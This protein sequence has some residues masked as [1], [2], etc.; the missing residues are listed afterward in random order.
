[1][2][3]AFQQ[4]PRVLLFAVAGGAKEAPRPHVP[5]G[6]LVSE[7]ACKR[8]GV[9]VRFVVT[10]TSQTIPVRY[11]GILP[12]LFKEG[13]GVVAQGQV[14][15]TA[16]SSRARCSPSTTRTTCRPMPRG[17]EARRAANEKR[18]TSRSHDD[19]ELGQIAAA[20][21][22][23]RCADPGHAAAGRRGARPRRLDGA[24]R[25]P[26]AQCVLCRVA[27]A[28]R[29]RFVRN[30]FSVLYVASNSTP[31]A[32]A[33]RSPASGA[34]TKARCCCGYDAVRLGCSRVARFSR[35]CRRRW[36]R[37]SSR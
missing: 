1:V 12:D 23:R 2:L 31:P 33:Y 36:W 37:A 22:A 11:E 30:D 32:A 5:L 26:A 28:A 16:C 10:D 35:H 29:Q 25:P 15:A 21:R 7:A 17:A 6:G 24:A 20:A 9:S 18:R 34:A 14:G 3:N 19:P 4:Q 8:D 13:K 27:F